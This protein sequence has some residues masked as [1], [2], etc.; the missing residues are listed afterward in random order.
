MFSSN[1]LQ[2]QYQS[3]LS[4]VFSPVLEDVRGT[5]VELVILLAGLAFLGSAVLAVV[6]SGI[7]V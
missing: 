6:G 4:R 1:E 2:S 7:N 3:L 5:L